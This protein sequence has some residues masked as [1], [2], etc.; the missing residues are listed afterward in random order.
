MSGAVEIC[1]T[2]LEPWP[3]V[4]FR[5]EFPLELYECSKGAENHVDSDQL[6]PHRAPVPMVELG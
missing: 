6:P 2:G 3:G 4:A 1:L 5:V